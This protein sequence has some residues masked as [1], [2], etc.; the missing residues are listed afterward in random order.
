MCK[1]KADIFA[2]TASSKHGL[3]VYIT[4]Y[5]E[6]KSDV[7]KWRE[8]AT[9]TNTLQLLQLLAINCSFRDAI[10]QPVALNL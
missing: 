6:E 2:Q 10:W 7:P 1:I 8:L 4:L 5:M 9:F 3:L